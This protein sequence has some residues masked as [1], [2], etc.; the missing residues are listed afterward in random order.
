M[1][2]SHLRRQLTAEETNRLHKLEEIADKLKHGENVQS[3]V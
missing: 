3:S 2:E 1:Y